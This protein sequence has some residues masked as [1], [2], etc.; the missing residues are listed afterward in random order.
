MLQYYIKH[1]ENI[2]YRQAGGREEWAGEGRRGRGRR[3]R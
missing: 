3:G 2:T 1:N